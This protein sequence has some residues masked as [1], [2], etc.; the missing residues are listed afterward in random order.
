M[1][2]MPSCIHLT[3]KQVSLKQAWVRD[4]EAACA[5]CF[6]HT[7]RAL[8]LEPPCSHSAQGPDTAPLA[9]PALPKP[10]FA[11]AGELAQGGWA[12]FASPRMAA[13]CQQ[14]ASYPAPSP[15]LNPTVCQHEAGG[16]ELERALR[17]ENADLRRALREEGFGIGF[18]VGAAPP[19]RNSCVRVGPSETIVTQPLQAA[20]ALEAPACR[21][22]PH[23]IEGGGGGGMPRGQWP[24]PTGCTLHPACAGGN[25]W[26]RPCDLAFCW[27]Y[28]S[29]SVLMCLWACHGS[30]IRIDDARARCAFVHDSIRGPG[31]AFHLRKPQTA[32]LE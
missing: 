10:C 19:L 8:A 20:R 18:H 32:C 14:G 15:D 11:P 6:Q 21:S 13:R 1:H 30:A 25:S 4:V 24:G 12:L 22:Q 2:S 16:R 17:E 3:I 5:H 31:Q 27:R 29:C 9:P 28:L 7:G 26:W 23:G